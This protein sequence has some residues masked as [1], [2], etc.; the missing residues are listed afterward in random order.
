M[1]SLIQSLKRGSKIGEDLF[2]SSSRS[3]YRSSYLSV[4]NGKWERYI[5]KTGSLKFPLSISYGSEEQS[6]ESDHEIE[7]NISDYEDKELVDSSIKVRIHGKELDFRSAVTKYC[8]RG[9]TNFGAKSRRKIL[10]GLALVTSV[11]LYIP[12]YVKLQQK[13]YAT[14]KRC[15]LEEP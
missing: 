8:N 7:D 5:G 15:K 2:A 3:S 13:S 4:D 6:D 1:S 14:L 10:F 11:R 12:R 9:K